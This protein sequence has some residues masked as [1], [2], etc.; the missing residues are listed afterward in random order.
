MR[1]HLLWWL[2]YVHR[3]VDNRLITREEQ[4]SF[5]YEYA[6]LDFATP[7]GQAKRGD[8]SPPLLPRVPL[9]AYPNV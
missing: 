9:R 1:N 8:L 7:E 3:P 2:N 5:E 6:T 4:L